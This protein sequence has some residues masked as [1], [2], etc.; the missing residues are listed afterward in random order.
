M[1]LRG[2][3]G[4]NTVRWLASTDPGRAFLR[5]L[6]DVHG[7]LPLHPPVASET[8]SASLL[9]ALGCPLEETVRGAREIAG[10]HGLL[11][12]PRDTAPAPALDG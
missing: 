1:C 6:H 12:F 2:Y 4:A 7:R 3:P 5:V 8:D 10:W 11:A 9:V